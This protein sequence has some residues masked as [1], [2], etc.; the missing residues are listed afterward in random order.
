[1]ISHIEALPAGNALRLYLT[2]PPA[3]ASWRVLR[4]TSA[5]AFTGPDDAGAVVV[6][7]RTDGNV[8]LDSTALENGFL[9]HYRV[10]YRDRRGV[11]IAQAE[12]QGTPAASYSGEE[13]DVLTVLRD[14]IERGL[15]VEVEREALLPESGSIQVLTAPFALVDGVNFPCVSVHL[16]SE[17]PVHRGIGETLFAD[18]VIDGE[19]WRETEGWLARVVLRVV[20]VSLNADERIAL[21][22]ALRRIIL[23]NLPVLDAHGILQPEFT[24][25]DHEDEGPRQNAAILF[26][27][28]GQFSCIAPVY[29]T[30]DLGPIRDVTVNAGTFTQEIRTYG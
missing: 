26:M 6:E 17:T 14:R 10:H 9:Y 18:D 29:V 25:S 22:R 7:D 24:V 15:K 16:E 11:W 5:A 19:L 2:P 12:G 20:A 13:L 23:A 28:V 8:V 21:R 1:M 4:R 27:A 30:R 3:A